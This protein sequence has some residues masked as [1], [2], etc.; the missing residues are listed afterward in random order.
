M[1]VFALKTIMPIGEFKK[2][3]IFL[4][5]D[6]PDVNELQ[7][8]VLSTLVSTGLGDKKAK[9]ADFIIRKPQK[10]KTKGVTENDVRGALGMFSKKAV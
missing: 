5:D 10:E 2:W 4:K 6:E 7:M 9:V 8:A 1:P 3:M